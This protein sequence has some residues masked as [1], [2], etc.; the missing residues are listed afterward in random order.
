MRYLFR[1]VHVQHIREHRLYGIAYI[2]TVVYFSEGYK[3]EIHVCVHKQILGVAVFFVCICTLYTGGLFRMEGCAS[4]VYTQQQQ[5]HIHTHKK[6]THRL[7]LEKTNEF[8]AIF[9]APPYFFVWHRRSEAVAARVR[10]VYLCV[11]CVERFNMHIYR[12]N[13]ILK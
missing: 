4:V 10:V 5:H 3:C 7:Y 6:K 8:W 11:W 2:W 13:I 12:F 9:F 1:S